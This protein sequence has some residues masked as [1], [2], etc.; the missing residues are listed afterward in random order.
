VLTEVY[1][2]L[3]L[4]PRAAARAPLRTLGSPLLDDIGPKPYTVCQTAFD[5][6]FPAGN[7]NYWKSSYLTAIGDGDIDTLVEH[8]NRAPTPLSMIA[9]EHMLAGAVAR[10]GLEETAFTAREAAYNL[11]ILG[12]GADPGTD[13]TIK[14]WTRSA[15]EAA[16]PFSTGAVYVNYMDRDESDR[17]EQAYGSSYARLQQL[18]Q[19]FDPE[20]RFRRNQNVAPA[21]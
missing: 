10:V 18:K 3:L 2:G 21:R 16:R 5:A 13:D 1:A 8:A 11:L 20:N 15:W 9:V 19:Q 6:G 17:L 14:S 7:R 12:V 4:H